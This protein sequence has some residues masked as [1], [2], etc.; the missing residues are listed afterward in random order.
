MLSLEKP[1]TNNA[2]SVGKKEHYSY[3]VIIMKQTLFRHKVTGEVVSQIL[4]T[5]ISE[6]EKIN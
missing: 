6:Y 1:L 3:K 2:L 5:R 4:L